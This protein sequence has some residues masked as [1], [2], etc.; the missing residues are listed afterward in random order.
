MIVLR[1]YFFVDTR[2]CP[3]YIR[4]EVLKV[5]QSA[6][7]PRRPG[8]WFSHFAKSSPQ[9]EIEV[10]QEFFFNL[11]SVPSHTVM[12]YLVKNRMDRVSVICKLALKWYLIRMC[13]SW[14]CPFH[15]RPQSPRSFWPV[16]GI[17]I[18]TT[19]Q[20]NRGPWGR[21]CVSLIITIL[22]CASLDVRKC[23]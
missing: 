7:G 16:V 22:P 20:K 4:L 3:I 17:S 12:S 18:P 13:T 2:D 9:P 19:G 10:H 1:S 14:L 11:P 23:D 21:E 15:S 5:T 6:L 8:H